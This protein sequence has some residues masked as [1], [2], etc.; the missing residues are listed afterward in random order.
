MIGKHGAQTATHRSRGSAGGLASLS[1]LPEEVGAWSSLPAGLGAKGGRGHLL[2]GGGR[3][4]GGGRPGG[5]CNPLGAAGLRALRA[6]GTRS[7]RDRAAAAVTRSRPAAP[8][9][10][11]RRRRGPGSPGLL[12]GSP[13]RTAPHRLRGRQR[14]GPS[15]AAMGPSWAPGGSGGRCGPRTPAAGDWN[16]PLQR[17]RY[18]WIQPTP[19]SR[20]HRLG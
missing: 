17:Q 11:C 18:P 14:R 7:C 13:A 16:P 1:E 8:G 6:A 20:R 10:R 12:P 19:G 3:A 5:C 4:G 15:E 9:R 2:P